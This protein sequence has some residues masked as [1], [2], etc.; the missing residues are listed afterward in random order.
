MAVLQAVALAFLFRSCAAVIG[1]Q[2]DGESSTY[3]S[4]ATIVPGAYIVKFAN[5]H[6]SADSF[7][8]NLS[9]SRIDAV[10]RRTFT[11]NIFP[12]TSFHADE[13]DV[14]KILSFAQVES[15]SPVMLFSVM[16]PTAKN[17]RNVDFSA[18][19]AKRD[20]TVGLDNDTITTH[21]MTGVDKLH[22]E[23]YDG[24]GV[25]IA[26][27]DSG[28]DYTLPAL[29]GGFGPGYKVAFG[30]DLVGDAY[31]GLTTPVPDDDPMDC[32]GHG[33]HVAGIIA[34]ANDPH[35]LGV[36]PNVVLGS[37][38]V[39][40]CYD[41]RVTN[42]ILI[43]AF[44]MAYEDG[45]DIITASIGFA[46]GWPEEPW[47]AAVSAIVEAGV[48]CTLAAGNDGANGI[49]YS[50][51]AASGNDVTAV[52]SVEN[53]YAPEVL[54]A[55][56]YNTNGG[57]ET[58]FGYVLGFG[59]YDNISMEI[60]ADTYDMTVT[61]DACNGFPVGTNL[62]NKIALI[63]RGTC[64]F[65]IKAS[66]A[67]SAGAAYVIF[68]NNVPGVIDIL[69]TNFLVSGAGM[70][71]P[72][73]GAKWIN[74]L[75]AGETVTLTFSTAAPYLVDPQGPVNTL[76]GGYMDT[77]TTWGLT[78]ENTIKPVV[79]APGGTIVSTYLSAY[80]GYAIMSGTSMATPFIAGVVAL[81]LQ[82]KK[83]RVVTP[84]QINAALSSTA[85]P[86]EYND[87]TET[88]PYLASVAQQGEAGLVNA[89][90]MIHA[91][92]SFSQYNVPLNDTGNFVKEAQVDIKNT[93]CKPVTF[94]FSH[95]PASNVYALASGTSTSF[96]KYPVPVDEQ[97]STADITPS[98]LTL[99]PGESKPIYVS[100]APNPNLDNSRV[101]VYSGYIKA[102]SPNQ[103]YSIP[104][105]GVAATMKELPI[106]L[107][108][109]CFFN[110]YYA[111][112]QIPFN[113]TTIRGYSPN[114]PLTYYCTTI[115]QTRL[116]RFDIVNVNG[117]SNPNPI[118][119]SGLQIEGSPPGFPVTNLRRSS[120]L[121]ADFNGT[122]AE[123]RAIETGVYKFVA[124][125]GKLLGDF[126]A[127]EYEK[128]E[129]ALFYMDMS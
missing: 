46:N 39:F 67:L 116:V 89:Y 61:N 10:H 106:T 58:Q 53:T 66:A 113:G 99:A 9:D 12:G 91:R 79:S 123:G 62:T 55:A 47:A 73:T 68:Y 19:K 56:T 30:T 125:L 15:I 78:N 104:Y 51:S 7:Y 81:Y 111:P 17:V 127:G 71:E 31:N 101:P 119:A 97:Y 5:G 14:D 64:T 42:D 84:K 23:G 11:S 69:I 57:A 128:Y 2:A 26:I 103:T 6:D 87:G 65:D 121:A 80:G 48:P 83:G 92:T 93:G 90:N 114:R 8:R 36:A 45:A 118:T 120:S 35:I 85:I 33:T 43:S 94:T 107:P 109:S 21:V 16:A 63:R 98:T 52:G 49:F 40:G 32:F 82:S 25:K 29:G 37:Y 18:T 74:A 20:V 38:K 115:W 96:V 13:A 102:D 4:N 1:P 122:L 117:S 95:V 34:A 105:A 50:S 28:V 24:S 27:V 72:E 76:T 54:Q 70:V 88:Y 22:K 124:R 41:G 86:L 44:T 77:F 126:D 60:W 112:T 100:V 108:G 129:S 75:A 110:S 59:S 3:A